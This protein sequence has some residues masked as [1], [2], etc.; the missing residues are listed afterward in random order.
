MNGT[1]TA[2]P[3]IIDTT[4]AQLFSGLAEIGMIATVR[5]Q[6]DAGAGMP[7]RLT[8]VPDFSRDFQ[9]W[10]ISVPEWVTEKDGGNDH[11]HV[12]HLVTLRH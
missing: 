10:E 1:P 5:L 8:E 6:L 7:L 4:V 9:R 2:T 11:I 3:R 12:G